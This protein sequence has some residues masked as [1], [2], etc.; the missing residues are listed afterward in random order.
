MQSKTK[1]LFD[2]KV[3]AGFLIGFGIASL[4]WILIW[5]LS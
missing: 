5:R 2:P 3:L 1:S 4:M